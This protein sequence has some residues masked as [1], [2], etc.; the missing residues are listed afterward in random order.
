MSY[1]SCVLPC[2]LTLLK[3][4]WRPACPLSRLPAGT[5]C[6][7][8]YVHVGLYIIISNLIYLLMYLRMSACLCIHPSVCLFICLYI[9]LSIYLICVCVRLSIYPSICESLE[10]EMWILCC[11]QADTYKHDDDAKRWIY[12]PQIELTQWLSCWFLHGAGWECSD[13]LEGRAAFV[14]R[15]QRRKWECGRPAFG[16]HQQWKPGNLLM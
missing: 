15:L 7:C 6:I 5:N 1:V 16:L 10:T 14:F 11:L 12:F 2:W 9:C 4:V 13:G 3:M 8:T